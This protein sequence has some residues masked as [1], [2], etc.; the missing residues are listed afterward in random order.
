MASSLSSA[1]RMAG[2]G[3][4][5][6]GDELLVRPASRS[7]AALAARA[8]SSGETQESASAAASRRTILAASLLAAAGTQLVDLAAAPSASALV[9]TT[10]VAGRIPGLSEPDSRGELKVQEQRNRSEQS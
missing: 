8:Q 1:S 7:R 3:L 4:L 6:S 5:A 9:P 2:S 10:A